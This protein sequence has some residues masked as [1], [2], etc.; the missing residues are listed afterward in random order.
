MI[1]DSSALIA[2][3]FNEQDAKKFF[4]AIAASPICLVGAP[5]VFETSLVL[6]SKEGPEAIFDLDEL[7]D[8]LNIK[9]VD[10]TYA[11]VRAA[12][13][14]LMKFGKGQGHPAQLN[15]GDCMSYAMAKIENMPLLFKGDDFRKTDIECAI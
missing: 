6:F 15:F 14:A 8:R 11:H 1:V 12:R 5:T 2:I 9:I 10:F 13:S 3:L 7:M 4:D